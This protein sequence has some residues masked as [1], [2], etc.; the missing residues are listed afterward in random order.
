[1]GYRM[2]VLSVAGYALSKRRKV[3][4]I[5]SVPVPVFRKKE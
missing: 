1:M 4:I 5:E 3:V 2:F